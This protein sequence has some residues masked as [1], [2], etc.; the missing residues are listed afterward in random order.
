MTLEEKKNISEMLT[1]PGSSRGYLVKRSVR[2][3]VVFQWGFG[4]T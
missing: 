4:R 1:A 2:G 3:Q